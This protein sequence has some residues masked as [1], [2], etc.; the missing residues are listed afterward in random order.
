M[1]KYIFATVVAM[2]LVAPQAGH[3]ATIDTAALEGETQ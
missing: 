2:A 3:A 1:K